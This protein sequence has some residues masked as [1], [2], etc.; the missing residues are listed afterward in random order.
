MKVKSK[1]SPI[2]ENK[3]QIT[4][5]FSDKIL[6]GA[7]VFLYLG[8]IADYFFKLS[9][10]GNL[11]IWMII[12]TS[13]V[14]GSYFYSVSTNIKS[15][16]RFGLYFAI[17]NHLV[18]SVGLIFIVPI[19]DPYILLL[20]LLLFSDG[21]RFGTKG[22]L[23]NL[24]TQS[25]TVILAF[26]VQHG[27]ND[28][29]IFS[30]ILLNL[31]LLNFIGIFIWR[32]LVADYLER[33]LINQVRGEAQLE[34]DRLRSLINSMDAAVIATNSM[35]N[36]TMYNGATLALLNTNLSL[37][38]QPLNKVLALTDEKGQDLDI[39]A[40]A[41]ASNL[42]LRRNDVVLRLNSQDSL[43][44]GISV[45]PVKQSYG[46][47]IGEGFVIT[48]R[49]I[50][51]E[52]SLDEQKDDFISVTSHELRTPVAIIEAN[53]ST[54]LL[55]AM[56][57]GMKKKTRDLI[58]AAHDNTIF[59]ANLISD[60][61]TLARAEKEF[62]DIDLKTIDPGEV[63]E[64]IV[65]DYSNEAEVKGL[66]IVID[67]KKDYHKL[68]TSELYVHEVLQ[69]FITNSIKYSKKGVITIGADTGIDNAIR[70]WVKDNGIGMSTSD[71][72]NIFTKFFRSEDYRTRETGG[73]GLGL[74]IAKKLAERM[75]G[76]VWCE[77]ELNKGSVFYLEIPPIGALS[78]DHKKITQA[79]IEDVADSL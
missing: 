24:G 28:Q 17:I 20:P 71:K 63:L 78:T 65:K 10:N 13:G 22:V 43:N 36:I 40:E 51:K 61:A 35:G 31:V 55:G 27:L 8:L 66:K 68:L 11:L 58:T 48:I 16:S 44:L 9:Y 1:D 45:A 60:L 56:S 42:V 46:Q 62:L 41:K 67:P 50:T 77:S 76:K 2:N 74:Y 14:I 29:T 25:L 69:N 38:N 33:K 26:I 79:E 4:T 12:I 3:S 49:D 57:K 72:K 21:F 15:L 32:M 54:A 59:L 53:L 30:D 7:H 34:K 5:M 47:K 6:I 70:F 73:T 19:S 37:E 75:G 39:I 52:R 23:I 64:E 18:V